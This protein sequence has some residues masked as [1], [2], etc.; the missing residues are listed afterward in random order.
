MKKI[1]A[2]ILVLILVSGIVPALGSSHEIPFSG[3]PA[4]GDVIEGFEAKEIREFGL[5]GARLVYF[6]HLKTGAKLLYIAND[7]TNR[8]FQLTFPTRM[9]D[10]K[11]L[12]HV[13][14]H[15]TLSGSEK[16]PSSSLW[17]NVSNQTYNTYMNAYTTDAMTSYPVASLSE[18]QLLKL[19]DMYTDMCLNPKIMT[20]ESIYRT[21]AWRYEMADPD[22]P[23]T[24]NGTVYSEMLGARTLQRATLLAANKTTFPGASV[25]YEYGGD[26]DVI[27]EMTWEDLKDY[28][29]RYYHP[30]NCLVLLYGSFEDYTAFLK[31]LNEAF[32]PFDKAEISLDEP[33]YAP[34]TE[35]ASCDYAYPV[36]EGTDTAGQTEI[37]YYILCPGMKG[38]VLQEQLVD[39]V[40][41]LLSDSASP[42]MQSLRKTFPT[43][44]FGLGRE[45]AAPD[46]A[47]VFTA[48]GMN[49]GDAEL[50]RVTVD[51]A[52]S[53][54]ARNGFAPELVDNIATSLIFDAKLAS[55]DS[56]PV[57]SIIYQFA[58]TYAVTGNIFRYADDYE[59]LENIEEE[60]I[61]G[62]LADTVSRWLTEPALYT[63][64]EG[65]PAPGQKEIH[66]AALADKLAEIKAGMTDE[67]KKA[68]LDAT[69]ADPDEEDNSD[70]LADLTAVTVATLPEEVRTYE[71]RDNLEKDGFRRIEAT[72]GVDG[73]SYIMLNLDA[74]PLPPE[75]IHYMRLYTRLLGHMDTDQHTW[76][77]LDPLVTRYLHNST[78]GVFVSGWKGHFHPY[79]VAEWYSLDEDLEAGYSL[80]EE[81]L[82]HTQFTDT[83]TLLERIQ[84]Q[85]TYVRGQ[86]S[87]SPYTVLLY[88]QLGI[89]SFSAR[90]YSYL[91]YLEYYSFLEELEQTLQEHPEEVT[92]RLEKVQKFFSGRSGAIAAAA[93]SE[94][95]LELNR[96]LADA[97]MAKLDNTPREALP[98]DLPVPAAKEGL[99][100]DTNIQFNIISAPWNEID[101]LADGTAYSALSQ[102]VSDQ[103]LIPDLRDQ[104]GA[105][106]AYCV[107]DGEEIY[108]FTYRDPN[109]SETFS[110]F[111]MLPDKV[112]AL[113]MDQETVNRYIISAYSGLAKPSG[114]LAGAIEAINNRISGA[115]DDLKIHSMQALKTATPDTLKTFAA[116][117][118]D[119]LNTNIR[120]TAGSAS[121][122]NANAG[123]FDLVLNPFNTQDLAAAGFEDVPEDHEL[124][125]FVI[126]AVEGGFITPESETVFGLDSEATV[127]DYFGGLYILLGGPGADAEACAEFLAQYG[128]VDAGINLDDPLTEQFACDLLVAL[129]AEISTD[130][131]DHI[132]TRGELARLFVE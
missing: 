28:H 77:E 85:K 86:I 80:A 90:Y 96:P 125:S 102:L 66:D 46:D 35:S 42:L 67:E 89:S 13:F 120:G 50:F 126:G 29:N 61:G 73:I 18:T 71:I 121:A 64:T 124:Y 116:Y 78:F 79:V 117:L 41:S 60:N 8:A 75:D 65:N 14:E 54:V 45:V 72:A 95:S 100:A 23:L 110:Y 44:T 47:I 107:S 25:S 34:I 32:I 87:Q 12:P 5:I 1:F 106:G 83:Q 9:T 17:F 132:M 62:Q 33:E 49:T 105:Y 53:E 111:D 97:F 129:G 70:M 56:D 30:S 98:F 123:I 69:N 68:V 128:L 15:G 6:E 37:Y 52:L 27:P 11:G 74:E 118:S 57:D 88:R 31:M 101:P 3:I 82:Y 7:D 43:G 84:A 58:Y 119:L 131:P 55:E 38:D 4:A 113:E 127:R 22:A 108:L 93:G 39:H 81:I 24:Y 122:V 16:Y 92:A 91:N 36:A 19:A 40:C 2:L 115:P 109:I 104:G 48:D 103:L 10:D 26:P 76:E 59:A 99:I 21:E 63:L 20:D 112:S 94:T 51:S 114:E 130:T